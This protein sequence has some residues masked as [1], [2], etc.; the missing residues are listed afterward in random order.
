[1]SSLIELRRYELTARLGDPR[2][3]F[4]LVELPVQVRVCPLT[5]RRSRITPQRVKGESLREDVW[6][7][8]TEAVEASRA[9]CP[10]CPEAVART[11]C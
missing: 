4:E 11:T 1:M 8:V 9:N 3:D 2:R 5:G 6:P 10:F 7:D